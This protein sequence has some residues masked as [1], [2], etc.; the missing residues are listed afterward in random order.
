M[1]PPS[2]EHRIGR[3]NLELVGDNNDDGSEEKSIILPSLQFSFFHLFLFL[4]SSYASNNLRR[5]LPFGAFIPYTSMN[6]NETPE[7]RCTY[8]LAVLAPRGVSLPGSSSL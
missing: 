1:F 7:N 8:V 4:E 6:E 5:T 3:S 2:C